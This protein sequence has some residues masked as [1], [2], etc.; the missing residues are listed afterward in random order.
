MNT[1]ILIILIVV[2]VLS[3]S[4]FFVWKNIFA[5]KEKDEAL[6]VIEEKTEEKEKECGLKEDCPDKTCFTKDCV[7]YTCSYS[8]IIPC[9]GNG[10][11]ETGETYKECADDCVKSGVLDKGEVWGGTIHVTGDVLILKDLTILPGTIVGFAVQDDQ[12]QGQEIAADGFNDLD[13]TRLVSY[14]KMHSSL[15]VVGKLIAAGTP[16]E[17]IIFTSA[18]ENPKIADWEVINPQGDGSLIE[19]ATI[20]W[21]RGGISLGNDPKPNSIFRNNRIGYTMW[22]SISTGWSSA[23]VYDNEIYECGHEGIDVQGGNP[24]IENNTIYDCHV[25]IVVLR[26]SAVV[27]NNVM[28]NVGNGIHVGGDATPVLE[29]NQIEVAPLGSTKEWCYGSFCYPMF[30]EPEGTPILTE[31]YEENGLQRYAVPTYRIENEDHT[32]DLPIEANEWLAYGWKDDKWNKI[33]IELT[34]NEC[35][36][37]LGYSMYV[38]IPNPTEA[39]KDVDRF[40]REHA[41]IYRIMAV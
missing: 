8:Q 34:E 4:G 6:L 21:S 16:E 27:R 11:C 17:R 1:K 33:E 40:N 31:V 41:D 30:G 23:Q 37:T 36:F 20:E 25:G 10:I 14:G 18:A 22:G 9:C 13:P 32:V 19:Y 2:V 35:K 12:R 26:G 39:E 28:T 7:D 29:N 38:L 5:P 24:I 15:T 3:I